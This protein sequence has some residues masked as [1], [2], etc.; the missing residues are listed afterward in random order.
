MR[1]VT[2]TAAVASVNASCSGSS[3]SG[4]SSDIDTRWE[5]EEE[6]ENLLDRPK[7]YSAKKRKRVY[8][9]PK[10]FLNG[11]ISTVAPT[12]KRRSKLVSKSVASKSKISSPIHKPHNPIQRISR[13]FKIS[14][15]PASDVEERLVSPQVDRDDR[16][17]HLGHQ[18]R[19]VDFVRFSRDVKLHEVLLPFG[20]ELEIKD[21]RYT[22]L[23]T[24]S[25]T[26]G[27][28][29]LEE[30]LVLEAL[31]FYRFYLTSTNGLG[32]VPRCRG[33]LW[34]THAGS[35]IAEWGHYTFVGG[36]DLWIST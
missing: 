16:V 4:S 34:Q 13:N 19:I 5:F 17:Y 21:Q 29:L 36:I 10:N 28:Y 7:S 9:E 12:P 22:S 35:L 23:R 20:G 14:L 2:R 30:P 24:L 3:V 32:G 25:S 1:S 18:D 27:E 11:L 26:T 6:L 31:H 8:E 33:S 15:R